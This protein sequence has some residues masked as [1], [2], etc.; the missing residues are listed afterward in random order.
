[1]L[2]LTFANPADYDKIDSA[3]KISIVG[4]KDF[5]PGKSLK[6]IIKKANGTQIEI[7]LNHSF[8]EQQIEWFKA[9]SALN[10]M[11]EVLSRK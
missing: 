1:M 11:K 9:G 7:S 8:N 5:A 3:D 4:L 6:A 10:R 2:P